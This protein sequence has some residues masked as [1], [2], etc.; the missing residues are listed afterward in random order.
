V[1]TELCLHCRIAAQLGPRT[2]LPF[3]CLPVE[4]I[5]KL[6]G[7]CRRSFNVGSHCRKIIRNYVVR[8]SVAGCHVFPQSH[9]TL[10][11][12]Q[13]CSSSNITAESARCRHDAFLSRSSF[14]NVSGRVLHR[15]IPTL[16]RLS[17]TRRARKCCFCDHQRCTLILCFMH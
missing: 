4:M 10:S 13:A 14:R 8:K 2:S 9:H 1:S 5:T 16:T 6:F 3:I 11:P 15:R 17:H 7:S 12:L